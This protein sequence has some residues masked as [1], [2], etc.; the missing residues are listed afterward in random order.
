MH[1]HAA[2]S[3]LCVS[4]FLKLVSESSYSIPSHW[5][6]AIDSEVDKVKSWLGSQSAPSGGAW[7]T[8]YLRAFTVALVKATGQVQTQEGQGPTS[9]DCGM[10][11][12]PRSGGTTQVKREWHTPVT[13]QGYVS[14]LRASLDAS[15]IA[16]VSQ[17]QEPENVS[18]WPAADMYTRP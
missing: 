12:D 3:G 5:C 17:S 7:W 10:T 14:V 18:G 13:L 8:T 15:T 4:G 1:L 6:H 9:V 11:R 2:C 16:C